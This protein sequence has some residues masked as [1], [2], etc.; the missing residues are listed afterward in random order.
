MTFVDRA[1]AGRLLGERLLEVPL[2]S[3]IILALARGGVPV[4]FEV[5]AV[6][7]APLETLIVRKLGVPWHEELGMGAITENGF[8]WIDQRV[9]DYAGV[10][11]G[12]LDNVIAKESEE[13]ARRVKLY[14]GGAPLPSLKGHTAVIVDDGIAMGVTARAACSFARSAGAEKVVLAVP[15]CS[16]QAAIFL[17][18]EVN[19]LVCLHE[20]EFFQAVGEFYDNFEQVTD[21]EVIALLRKKRPGKALHAA[22]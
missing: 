22:A 11:P 10:L 4:G 1:R 17:R 14:R 15:V 3:P 21:A 18:E 7:G 5:A 19:E 9:V 2:K 8:R 13:L 12:S 20:P 16:A 6:L